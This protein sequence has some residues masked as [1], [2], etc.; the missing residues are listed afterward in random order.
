MNDNLHAFFFETFGSRDGEFFTTFT[1]DFQVLQ[2]LVVF[3]DFGD[4]IVFV[5]VFFNHF[6]ICLDI[7]NDLVFNRPLEKIQL[8]NRRFN[9]CLFNMNETLFFIQI[10]HPSWTNLFFF[11]S[12]R[13]EF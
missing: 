10:D 12:H 9:K 1:V 13:D 4:A 8:A 7:M 6:S 11:C 2:G 5:H 3:L